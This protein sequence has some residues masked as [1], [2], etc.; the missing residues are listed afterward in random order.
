MII[1]S[2]KKETEILVIKVTVDDDDD[3]D[4]DVVGIEQLCEIN[5]VSLRRRRRRFL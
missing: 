3:D 5:F 1:K 4:Q 2:K